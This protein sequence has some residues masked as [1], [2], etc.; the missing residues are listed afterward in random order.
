MK[1]LA[2]ARLYGILDLGYVAPA[3]AVDVARGMLADGEGVDV[4]QIRAK[5]LPAN[6]IL[7][8]ARLVRP[9]CANLGVPLILNDHPELVPPAGADGAHVGQDDGPLAAARTA[10]GTGKL[11]G[12]ST[13]GL[14]Q[15]QAARTEGADYLGFGPL[16]ATP[17]KPDYPAVG[18][19]DI[20]AV[21]VAVPDRPVFCIGGIKLENLP[22]VLAAGARRV[23][24]VSGLLL[25]EDVAGYART[26]QA[27]LRAVAWS[28]SPRP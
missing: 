25:A 23:V 28:G 27:R 12:R 5:N 14:A 22:A 6:D 4:L 15:A 24:I 20:A 18:L 3:D 2:D 11:L 10:A 1:P 19:E 13:H 17:T 21:H 9:L 16:F 7:E 26:A 8:L